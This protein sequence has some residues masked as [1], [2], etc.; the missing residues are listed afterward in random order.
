M[1]KLVL[2]R[3]TD[4]AEKERKKSE[5]AHE[6]AISMRNHEL[7]IKLNKYDESLKKYK[8]ERDVEGKHEQLKFPNIRIQLIRLCNNNLTLI[9][10]AL[11]IKLLS[12]TPVGQLRDFKV[13][14][15][16][17]LGRGI[18]H[19]PLV[20]PEDGM[21]ELIDVL[22]DVPFK[23][24][25]IEY[26]DHIRK[27]KISKDETKVRDEYNKTQDELIK[28]KETTKSLDGTFLDVDIKETKS[29]SA[30]CRCILIILGITATLI[31]EFIGGTSDPMSKI[32]ILCVGS[33]I[34]LLFASFE[35]FM[36]L[37]GD[38]L[39]QDNRCR[40][41]AWKWGYVNLMKSEN[42]DPANFQKFKDEIV[43]FCCLRDK[44]PC[45]CYHS[46]NNL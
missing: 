36:S 2:L 38:C 21:L 3:M 33:F 40:I 41:L 1:K 28:L 35:W 7:S 30:C 25:Y 24:A 22:N 46:K 15:I 26:Y 11:K 6:V 18:E 12:K 43:C 9:N 37:W 14:T 31:Y 19:G 8:N 20:F 4:D 13:D 44:F 10:Q 32:I 42:I 34:T 45:Y 27:A 39:D 5:D 23:S 16:A 29:N 17:D